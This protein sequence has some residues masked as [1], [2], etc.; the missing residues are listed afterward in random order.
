MSSDMGPDTLVEGLICLEVDRILPCPIQPRVN[1]SQN[2]VDKL[3]ASMAAGR[4]H[5]ILEVEP[6]PGQTDHYQIVCGEQRWRAAKAARITRVLARLHP[7]LGYLERLEKQYEENRLRADFDPVEEAHCLLLHKILRDI[8]VAERMLREALVPFEP[9]DSKRLTTREGFHQHLDGLKRLLVKRKVHT[10]K[11]NGRL[12]VGTLSPWRETEAALGVSEA[13]RKAK[14]G[15]LRLDDDLQQQARLLPAE[16]AIQIAKLED[17]AGQQQLLARAPELTHRQVREAVERLRQDPTRS[18][19][20]ALLSVK[21]TID[22]GD[23]IAM[24]IG[25]LTDLCREM[26]RLLRNFE[27]RLNIEQRDLVTG[28]LRTLHGAMV[29]YVAL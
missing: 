25:H 12:E 1:F 7:R 6:A 3:A 15:I 26:T 23:D 19:D 29:D 24:E 8:G 10:I 17:R 2:L 13:V 16:H 28:V 4:H 5:P 22:P 9:L 14:V 18:V 11:V 21:P 20:E 27:G